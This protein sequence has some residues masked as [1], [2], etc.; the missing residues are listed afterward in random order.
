[1][2]LAALVESKG[3][4]RLLQSCLGIMQKADIAAY[5][6]RFVLLALRSGVYRAQI[7][8]KTVAMHKAQTTFFGQV[9]WTLFCASH[10]VRMPAGRTV[11]SCKHISWTLC[12][13]WHNFFSEN[14][15]VYILFRMPP[16]IH[17]RLWWPVI[18]DRG[19]DVE[20]KIRK[21]LWAPVH[22]RSW[23]C[24]VVLVTA[25]FQ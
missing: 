17:W 21:A 7:C 6:Q 14:R 5:Y 18:F 25:A 24:F 8:V 16:F 13:G 4:H 1:M 10:V 2:R 19:S 22:A 20:A 15:I 12:S 3:S 11:F 23:K 9:V